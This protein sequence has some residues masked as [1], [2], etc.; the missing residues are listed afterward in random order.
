MWDGKAPWFK[1]VPQATVYPSIEYNWVNADKPFYRGLEF[2]G[3]FEHACYEDLLGNTY[4]MFLTDFA[5]VIERDALGYAGALKGN[6]IIRKRG[7]QYGIAL[8]YE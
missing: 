2:R 8:T 4:Q 5:Q 7:E 6:F 1:G 3:F